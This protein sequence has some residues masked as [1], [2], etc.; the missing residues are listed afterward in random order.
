MKIRDKILDFNNHTCVMGILN[1]TPDSFSDG[2]SYV[3]VNAAIEHALAM[4]MEGADIIDI[5]GESTRPGFT[6]VSAQDEI[7][8]VVPVI[9]GLRKVSDVIISI[10]TTKADVAQAAL[11]AGA[12][13]INDVSGFMCEPDIVKVAQKYNAVCI[14]MHD[15]AYFDKTDEN[16]TVSEYTQKVK[17]ELNDIVEGALNNGIIPEK[18]IVDP[19]IGF[20][21]TKRENLILL[22]N[23]S[24][25]GNGYPVLL[26]CSRKSVIGLSLDLPVTER[27]EGTIATS[28]CGAQ[29]GAAIV[30]VHDVKANYRAIKMFEAIRDVE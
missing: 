10:D 23:L 26:G 14:L 18:I 28:V 6:P 12:D 3:D 24:E 5:G 16:I 17:D 15:G 1:V 19:G 30:R 2:G 11:E 27:L 9:E 25:L 7:A 4:A 13:I 8:R 20:G 29:S 22:K 21:K